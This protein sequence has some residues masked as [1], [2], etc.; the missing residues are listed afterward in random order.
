MHNPVLYIFDET[1]DTRDSSDIAPA[2][3]SEKI[4]LCPVTTDQEITSLLIKSLSQA[5]NCNI[6][7]LPYLERFNKI[8]FSERNDFI[9]FISDLGKKPAFD[10]L[11]FTEYFK[12][13]N[14]SFSAWWT[15]SIVEKNPLKS[16]SYH[17]LIKLLAILDLQ[18]ECG[19]GMVI[20]DIDSSALSRT[21]KR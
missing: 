17:N 13:P 19:A 6:E 7:T 3:T 12:C 2:R 1:C 18:K 4:F 16:D 21:N 15:S 8:A 5:A 9:Q 10:N 11:S 14:S 20:L